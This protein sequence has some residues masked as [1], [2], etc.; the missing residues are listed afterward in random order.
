MRLCGDCRAAE[1]VVHGKDGHGSQ[2]SV[3]STAAAAD[4]TAALSS[5]N[6]DTHASKVYLAGEEYLNDE[7]HTFVLPLVKKIKQQIFTDPT[8]FSENYSSSLGLTEFTRRATE[9]ALGTNSRAVLENRV[10]GVQTVGFTG[11]VR[12]GAEL[13]R[14]HWYGIGAAWC[15]PVYLS[16]PFEAS[17]ASTFQAVGIQDVRQYYYWNDEQRGVGLEK[18][19]EDL[20]RAPEQSVVVLSASAHFPTGADLSQKQWKVVGQLM[21]RRSLLPFFLLPAQGLCYGDL[22]RDAWPLQ[23]F[24]SLGMELLCAQSFSLCFGLYGE[25]VGHLL[26][27][28]RQ[29]SI[30][31]AVQSQVEKLVRALWAQPSVGTARVI[32]TVLSNP[33]HLS[34]WQDEV[35]HIV[36]RCMLIRERLRERLRILGSPGCWDHLTQQG[37]LYSC[38][39]LNGQQVQ[40]LSKRRHIYLLPN[41]C[42]NVSAINSHN[43]SYVAQSIHEALTS[44]V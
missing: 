33:A 7:G 29:N 13:L 14:Q 10:L 9:L 20:E 39:G 30:L 8:L 36:E 21:M 4:A 28:L 38:T 5:F 32:A 40:F 15:G 26:C 43:L 27:V 22:E 44:P 11:A 19:L 12:L 3:F 6:R 42:L 37:G 16:S 1:G 18:L 41:G 34:E 35:K 25:H 24:E 17:L 31:L 2:V 23:Y